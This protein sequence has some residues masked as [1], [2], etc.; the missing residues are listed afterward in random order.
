MPTI[1]LQ[2]QPRDKKVTVLLQKVEAGKVLASLNMEADDL[3]PFMDGIFLAF[4]REV[5]FLHRARA[6]YI[7]DNRK[8]QKPNPKKRLKK[9]QPSATVC[10]R[11]HR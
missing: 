5:F 3:H 8:V 4:I 10:S 6:A 9:V 11:D 7:G 1:I 2:A